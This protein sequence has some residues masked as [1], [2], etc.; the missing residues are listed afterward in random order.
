[1]SRFDKIVRIRGMGFCTAEMLV[2]HPGWG[3]VGRET[4]LFFDKSMQASELSSDLD[5]SVLGPNDISTFFNINDSGPGP[6]KIIFWA[7]W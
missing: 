6:V 3:H 7:T 2:L 5:F 1:M 4:S